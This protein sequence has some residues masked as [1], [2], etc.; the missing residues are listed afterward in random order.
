MPHKPVLLQEVLQCL[1]LK[2]GDIVL[3][4]TLGSGGHALEILKRIGPSGRLIGLDQDTAAI[5]RCRETLKDFQGQISL[6]SENYRNAGNVLETLNIPALDAV[7]LDVGLSSEQLE[8]AVRG[9]S[10]DRSGP[11]DMRMDP[12]ASNRARDLVNDLSEDEL[13][14]L[15]RELGEERWA[16]RIAGNIFRERAKQP[17]ETTDD[18]VRVI[19]QALPRRTRFRKGHRPGWARRHPATR[20]FQALRIAANDELG[21]LREGLPVLWKGIK[22]GGRLAV[23]TFHSLEDRIVKHQFRMWAQTE[24]AVLLTK[25]P[26][27]AT[28]EEA[29]ANPRS[30]SAKLRVVEK[31]HER[32]G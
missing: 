29:V 17:I 18:L 7:I 23:I 22:P 16:R 8:D 24:G 11:L 14:R 1:N 19:E 26:I 13:E 30:R 15:F 4:G 2:S 10:F 27:T 21:A 32:C 20:A 28:R 31:S 6:H 5:V 25:K 9:F 12:R 3:D